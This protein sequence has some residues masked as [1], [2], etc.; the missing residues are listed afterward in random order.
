MR[1]AVR[2]ASEKPNFEV[3][4]LNPLRSQSARCSAEAMAKHSSDHASWY[5]IQGCFIER[6]EA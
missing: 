2:I 3:L 6:L 5:D 1:N 4:R